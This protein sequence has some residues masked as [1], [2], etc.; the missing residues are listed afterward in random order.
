MSDMICEHCGC[1]LEPST[2]HE[3]RDGFYC[4]ECFEEMTV[5]CDHCGQRILRD[6][7]EG[8]D[9]ICLCPSCYANYYVACDRCGR[10]ILYDDALYESDDDDTPYC[11]SCFHRSYYIHPY[12]YKPDPIFHGSSNRYFGV[13]LEVDDGGES[14]RSAEIIS[15]LANESD[16]NLY[17]KHDGSLNDGFE[18]VTHPMSL[19]YHCTQMPWLP[20]LQKLKSLGYRSHQTRTAGLHV[21]VNRDALGETWEEQESAIARILFFLEKH[22]EE[23]VKFSRRTQ[24]QLERWAN[25]YGLKNS[26]KEI[27]KTA[28]GTCDRYTCLNLSNRDTI[29]FR[30]FRGTLKYNSIIATLQLVDQIC[31]VALLLSDA[32]IRDLSWTSFVIECTQPELIQYLKERRLYVNDPVESE[33]DV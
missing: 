17:C 32:E 1:V 18:L 5:V 16:N 30:I 10:L 15:K 26:P 25:R 27:L 31:N 28:K 12:S 22:W 2:E 11:S 14:E 20:V 3:F 29:E 9:R 7:N 33:G 21:H 4:E 23:L 13:E 6:Q 8:D 19:E 24:G